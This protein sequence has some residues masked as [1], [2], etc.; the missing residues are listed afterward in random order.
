MNK[1]QQIQTSPIITRPAQIKEN[2]MHSMQ[3][4][5]QSQR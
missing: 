1:R 4:K 3:A 2:N 5:M